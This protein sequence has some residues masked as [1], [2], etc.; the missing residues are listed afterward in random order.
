[1][2]VLL[3]PYYGNIWES[4]NLVCKYQFPSTSE[5]WYRVETK[6]PH[7]FCVSPKSTTPFS[8]LNHSCCGLCLAWLDKSLAFGNIFLRLLHKSLF[9]WPLVY[10]LLIPD[11]A[12]P[13]PSPSAGESLKIKS[14]FMRRR[15]ICLQKRPLAINTDTV[16][17]L[18]LYYGFLTRWKT[19]K[20]TSLDLLGT[21][22]GDRVSECKSVKFDIGK[23]F[24]WPL[25]W[26]VLPCGWM[27]L[28]GKFPNKFAKRLCV[29]I[30]YAASLLH[31]R[32]YVTID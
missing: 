16:V 3:S 29:A 22:F 31:C 8:A 19:L 18:T 1:L 12:L 2:F 15:Q 4:P 28:Q 24:L 26:A 27:N 17:A 30:G 5:A 32:C 6:V 11:S 25:Y 13:R 21:H 10:S 9:V 20:I 7:R 23:G 14:P